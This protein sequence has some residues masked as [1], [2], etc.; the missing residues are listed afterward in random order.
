MRIYL[1]TSALVKLVVKEKESQALKDFLSA[2]ADDSWFSAALARTELIRAVAPSGA[3]AI[4]AARDILER[5]DTVMLTRQLLDD[6][7]TLRPSHLRSL[8][9]IHLAAA[10]RAGSSLRAVI[11]YDTRMLSAA[12]E[13]GISTASPR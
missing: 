3:R 11:T 4:A 10:Q 2:H 5:L 13:L 7:G 12:A 9:A 1:D 6:A 8:D